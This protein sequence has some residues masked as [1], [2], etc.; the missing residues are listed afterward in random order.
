MGAVG[1]LVQEAIDFMNSG[2]YSKG[3]V[4]T[5]FA[6]RATA[7]RELEKE[8]ASDFDLDRFLTRHW[9][10]IA[11]MGLPRALPLPMNI[12]FVLKR[13]IPSFNVHHGARE[14]VLLMLA[15][16]IRRGELPAEF[17][18]NRAGRFEIK[19]NRLLVPGGL[20]AG[21]LGSVIFHPTSRGEEIGDQYWIA[22]SDFKMFVSELFGRRDLA[23]RIMKFYLE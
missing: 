21:L 16:T 8:T 11:F 4:P 6:V 2:A 17:A 3:F 7:G 13:I 15:E 14:I 20:V 5:A 22:I 18:F 1:E 23:E 12:P 19:G 9:D 10:L